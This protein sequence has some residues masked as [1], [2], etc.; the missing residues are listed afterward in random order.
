VNDE[1]IPY[2]EVVEHAALE[3]AQLEHDGLLTPERRQDALRHSLDD[4]IADR[5]M[6]AE[7][8]TSSIEISDS[9]IDYAMDDVR[10]Q[11]NMDASSFEHALAS[12]GQTMTAYREKMR[13]DLAA[14]KLIGVKV[15]S[16]IKVGDEEVKAEYARRS[17]ADEADFEVHA[18]H[19]VLQVPRTPTPRR[20]MA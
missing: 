13:K 11:N 9:E 19:I 14:M 15:R 16:K 10:K 6:T 18:R 2:S 5:L 4:L 8:K 7:E 3:L 12:K 17:K 1:M 20:R